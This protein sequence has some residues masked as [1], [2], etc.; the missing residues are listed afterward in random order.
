MAKAVL[1][2]FTDFHGDLARA[3]REGRAKEFADHA[4]ENVPDPNAPETFQRSKLN[5]KQQ[6]SEEGKAW[7]AFTR[8]LLLLRQKHIVPL[9]SAARESSGTVLQTAPGFIAVSWRFPGGT[10]SLALNISATTVLLPDLPGKT[11]FAWPN[12]STGSLS[13]HSLIVRLAQGES[14]S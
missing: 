6:H 4:G 13:Q 2:F 11:L 7:L 10:L 3:V 1:S 14:A 12:E 9:L 8:E 5:W